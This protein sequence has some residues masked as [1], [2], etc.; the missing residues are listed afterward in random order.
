MPQGGMM[1]QCEPTSL[2]TRANDELP[3]ELGFLA[4]SIVNDLLRVGKWTDGGYVVPYAAV[5][6]SDAL[7]SCGINNDWS[8]EQAFHEI[9]P[10][11]A[12]HAY[13]HTISV[14]IFRKRF[15]EALLK[16]PIGMLPR[17]AL[18][19]R[20]WLWRDFRGFFGS[21]AR[22]FQEKIVGV[23]E[24]EGEAAL[25]TVFSRIDPGFNNVFVKIDIE[26]SEYEIID[27]L[28]RHAARI[29][30]LVIEFHNTNGQRPTFCRAIHDLK[31]EFEIVHLHGNNCSP[32]APDGLPEALEITFLR[33]PGLRLQK[34]RDLP[35]DIDRPN[36]SAR[37]DYSLRF[38]THG[39]PDPQGHT[40]AEDEQSAVQRAMTE[41]AHGR[42]SIGNHQ[43]EGA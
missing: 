12:I 30:A 35:L 34:R 22:H 21:N 37:A 1:A 36:T 3:S 13:D 24:R 6:S 5:R 42:E 2:D 43:S 11:A 32:I 10:A 25:D 29:S 16:C 23:Q 15:Y 14:D 39:L 17:V 28:L 4:P 9:N 41:S 19:E 26:G 38:P 33:R 18:G 27:A 20:L 31:H 40:Q 7:I 8:F